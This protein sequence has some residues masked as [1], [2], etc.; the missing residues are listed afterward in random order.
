MG[1]GIIHRRGR[2]LGALCLGAAFGLSGCGDPL[3]DVERL[4]AVDIAVAEAANIAVVP[5]AGPAPGGP[6]FLGRLF[7]REGRVPVAT[8]ADTDVT[9]VASAPADGG[10]DGADGP[11]TETGVALAS[12]QVAST[13]DASDRRRLF[14]FLRRGE[15]VAQSEDPEDAGPSDA[16]G[17]G[18]IAE[19][20]AEVSA[21]VS[22]EPDPDQQ[23]TLATAQTQATEA[24]RFGGLFGRLREARAEIAPP[25]PTGPDAARVAPGMAV[26]YGSLATNCEV[27][28]RDLG[29]RV[30]EQSGFRIWDTAPNTTAPRTH[31]ITGFSDDCAQ[32]VHRCPRD[33]RRCRHA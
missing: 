27:S 11:A 21:D 24:P 2:V 6:R 3:R 5:E 26:P 18:V 13:E 8:S 31:Y 28:R 32:T 16:D 7:G 29:R 12:A 23:V 30:A 22:A 19:V 25:V 10:L 4:S 15:A 9:D 20:S 17:D 14:G 1:A 33:L